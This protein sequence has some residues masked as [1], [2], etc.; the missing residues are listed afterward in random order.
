MPVIVPPEAFDLWLDCA[1][2]DAKT[3]AALIVPAREDL[4]EAYEISTAVNRVAND[5][6][7]AHRAGRD[8]AAALRPSR[9]PRRSA[10]RQEKAE[11][12]TRQGKDHC[13]SVRSEPMIRDSPATMVRRIPLRHPDLARRFRDPRARSARRRNA[14]APSAC[15]ASVGSAIELPPVQGEVANSNCRRRCR[16]V[17]KSTDTGIME[18]RT[19]GKGPASAL[20]RRHLRLQGATSVAQK[21]NQGDLSAESSRFSPRP[22]F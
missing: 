8:G 15:I 19:P 11:R 10:R 3:A 13:F 20:Q 21:D 12:A 22:V 14:D 17:A 6:A 5:N 4:L 7:G 18:E 2:V 1:K 9:S 16:I